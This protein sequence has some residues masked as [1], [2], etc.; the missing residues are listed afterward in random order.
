[1][2][3]FSKLSKKTSPPGVGELIFRIYYYINFSYFGNVL[4]ITI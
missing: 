4:L 1:L 3:Y 2:Y